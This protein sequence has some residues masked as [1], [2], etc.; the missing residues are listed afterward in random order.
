MP[1]EDRVSVNEKTNE[2]GEI[3]GNMIRDE[4]NDV[5][6]V[7]EEGHVELEHSD[8]I[9]ALSEIRLGDF[10]TSKETN[11]L[12]TARRMWRGFV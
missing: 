3:S 12:S 11:F 8:D 10:T 5:G 1:V 6:V 2:R 9:L 4:A 7:V